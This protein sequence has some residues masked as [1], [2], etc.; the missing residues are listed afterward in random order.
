[1][2]WLPLFIVATVLLVMVGFVCVWLLGQRQSLAAERARLSGQIADLEHGSV[3]LTDE[4]RDLVN[5]LATTQS[6]LA[7]ARETIKGFDDRLKE[8]DEQFAKAQKLSRETFQSLASDELK[9]ANEQFLQLAR[10][11]FESEQ[12]DAGA[13]LEQRKQAIEAMLKPIRETLDKHAK[14]V[15]EIEKQR[16][17]AYGTLRQHLADLR[18]AQSKLGQ[19][20]T[21][22]T[23]ALRGSSATRG[24]WGEIALRRIAEMAGMVANC[25]FSEQVTY[26]SGDEAQRPDMV[27][28]MPADR[29]IIVDAKSVGNAYLQACEE[30]DEKHRDTLLQQHLRD[31]E[32][33]VRQLSS[34]G[35]TDALPRGV[36]FVVL[37]IPGD[38]FLHPAVMQRPDLLEWAMG[39]RVVIATPTTLISLLKVIEMGW[40]EEKIH[41]S[42]QQIRDLGIEMH[43]RVATAT[44]YVE[45][46]GTHLERA[47]KSYNQFVG[48]FEGRVVA[49][50]RRFKDM[51][52]DSSKELP[53]DGEL[54]QI[55]L[56]PRGV[57]QVDV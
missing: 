29:R 34:K 56:Q 38:S 7:V 43:E 52:A 31:I 55:E 23:T 27:V 40:R 32:S 15:T 53:A 33:R 50:A 45:S 49:T 44:G 46:L 10:K 22:L 8:K 48:S 57:K 39:Q 12:K 2:V 16:E 1:M 18:E 47:V 17:S 20:T 13:Q 24:R 5:Q 30:A 54:K 36:D 3:K 6:D 14:A 51:G 9:K 28:N 35:Y 26:W 4:N 41:E 25:D 37:F 42:A 11:T 21:A 19:Q